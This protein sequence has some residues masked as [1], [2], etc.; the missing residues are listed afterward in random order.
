[1][2]TGG[3]IDSLANGGGHCQCDLEIAK[4]GPAPPSLA[5]PPAA[6]ASTAASEQTTQSANVPAVSASAAAPEKSALKDEPIYEVTM[7]PLVYDATARVQP[8]PDPQQLMIIVK[9]VQVRS[10]FVFRGR[11]EAA[12]TSVVRAVPALR[13]PTEA[14]PAAQPTPPPPKPSPAPRAAKP[15]ETNGSSV[16]DRVKSYWRHLWSKS[17]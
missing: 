7:P 11:V 1:M 6:L 5:V 14:T 13:P 17:G 12:A 10:E 16:V 9:R 3:R 15:A 8:E 4:A 2:L